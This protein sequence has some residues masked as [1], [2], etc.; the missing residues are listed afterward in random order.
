MSIREINMTAIKT[1]ICR[2]YGVLPSELLYDSS[3][4]AFDCESDC[5]CND[6]SNQSSDISSDDDYFDF[7]N[8]KNQIEKCCFGKEKVCFILIDNN[9]TVYG[10]YH[11]GLIKS[12]DNYVNGL[13][14]FLISKGIEI[15]EKKY[16]PRN[17]FISTS[18]PEKALYTV[19]DE[20]EVIFSVTSNP[21]Q[22]NWNENQNQIYSYNRSLLKTSSVKRLM[23]YKCS[24]YR[25]HTP[26]NIPFEM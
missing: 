26:S 22:I 20:T 10:H 25:I 24:S 12:K 18:F 13:T 5:E 8:C 11:P 21:F 17:F 2:L 4:N 9:D 3:M 19:G 7:F 6:V 16:H 23:I 15:Y 1:S 14:I